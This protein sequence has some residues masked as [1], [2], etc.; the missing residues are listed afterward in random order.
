MISVRSDPARSA[1]AEKKAPGLAVRGCE[2]I[3]SEDGGDNRPL[4]QV[5]R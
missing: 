1:Q 3:F 5:K 4:Q 2:S